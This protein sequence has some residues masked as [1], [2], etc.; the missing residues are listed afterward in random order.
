METYKDFEVIVFQDED[1]FWIAE[2]QDI[3]GCVSQGATKADALENIKDAIKES[4]F[5]Q[6]VS[7]F[8]E[9]GIKIHQ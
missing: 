6:W 7:Q 1:S 4:I 5:K 8:L 3:P 2:C 9:G